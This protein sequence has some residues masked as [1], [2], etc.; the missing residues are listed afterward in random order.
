MASYLIIYKKLG[1]TMVYTSFYNLEN[2]QKYF[3][4]LEKLGYNELILI[5]GEVLTSI[6]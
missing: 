3:E 1:K 2:A 6:K 4:Y 5:K